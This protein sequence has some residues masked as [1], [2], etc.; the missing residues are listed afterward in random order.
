VTAK[1]LPTVNSWLKLQHIV[2][3]A[4]PLGIAAVFELLLDCQF[5]TPE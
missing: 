5:K 2:L 4:K 1:L 3:K